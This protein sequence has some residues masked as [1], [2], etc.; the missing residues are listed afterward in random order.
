MIPLTT[1]ARAA[2]STARLPLAKHVAGHATRFSTLSSLAAKIQTSR[3]A[4]YSGTAVLL[5]AALQAKYGHTRNFY[6]YRFLTDKNPDD[7]ASF[8][9]GEEFMELYCVLPVIGSVLMRGAEFDDEGVVHTQGLPGKLEVSMVFSDETDQDTNVIAWFNK[10]ERFKDVW[11]GYTTW[12]MVTNFGFETKPDGRIECYHTG[13]YFRGNVPPLS[14]LFQLIFVLHA[15]YVVMATEH[16]IYH[17]AFTANTQDEEDM[18]EL[19]RSF[20]LW[21]ILR[22]HVNPFGRAHLHAQRTEPEAAKE[23]VKTTPSNASVLAK[24]EDIEKELLVV[25][26]ENKNLPVVTPRLTVQ[27]HS[28]LRKIKDDILMDRV[29]A[30]ALKD[31]QEEE[32]K[33]V[34]AYRRATL[35]AHERLSRRKTIRRLSSNK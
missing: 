32:I 26:R 17:H 22:D 33:G 6:E 13:E 23:S 16:H 7:L 25:L 11:R 34:R 31:E 3:L 27:R 1:I 29:L 10:R 4:K 2:G 24:E 28:T 35:A 9:G 19:S 8:Y 18:E 5:T 30:K 21:H 12:D 14:L 15:Y 20:F